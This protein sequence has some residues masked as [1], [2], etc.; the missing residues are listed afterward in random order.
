MMV[1]ISIP[2]HINMIDVYMLSKVCLMGSRF[3]TTA[4]L[5]WFSEVTFVKPQAAQ[6]HVTN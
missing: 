3:H 4:Q 2:P 5:K 1:N 6:S